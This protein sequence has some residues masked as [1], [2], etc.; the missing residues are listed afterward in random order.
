[1]C[2][3][4]SW[5]IFFVTFYMHMLYLVYENDNNNNNSLFC[6]GK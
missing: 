2:V 3:L 4:D 5:M 6:H 1:M